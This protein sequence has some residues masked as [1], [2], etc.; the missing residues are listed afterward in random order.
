MGR[1]ERDVGAGCH[2]RYWEIGLGLFRVNRVRVP[3]C[4]GLRMG[5]STSHNSHPQHPPRHNKTAMGSVESQVAGLAS[6]PLAACALVWVVSSWYL[7]PRKSKK[8]LNEL[9]NVAIKA[10]CSKIEERMETATRRIRQ[11]REEEMH[12]ELRL[13]RER[14]EASNK[15]VFGRMQGSGGRVEGESVRRTAS[16][17]AS[18]SGSSGS[19]GETKA[20][21]K[22]KAKTKR[23]NSTRTTASA[24]SDRSERERAERAE[25]RERG[26]RVVVDIKED[27]DAARENCKEGGDFAELERALRA[28][29]AVLKRCQN[30]ALR[31]LNKP[32]EFASQV[33]DL[34]GLDVFHTV[35]NGNVGLERSES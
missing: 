4:N 21:D 28:L 19:G 20:G 9:E 2:H 1:G 24:R 11:R 23:N 16:G 25:L 12:E 5:S 3:R 26:I 14:I 6:A 17:S 33:L 34:D 32:A 35:M 13:A 15:A 31:G 8:E 29:L 10:W 30:P 27:I 18:N 22:A 7:Y